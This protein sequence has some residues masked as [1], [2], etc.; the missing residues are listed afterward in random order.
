[1]TPLDLNDADL[2]ADPAAV[3]A[4][5]RPNTVEVRFAAEAGRIETLEG[6]VDHDSGAAI[7]QGVQGERWPLGA[8]RFRTLYEPMP[9]TLPGGNGTYRKKPVRVLAK[10]V[11]SA[12]FSV[13]VGPRQQPIVGRPGDWLI[14]YSGTK[15][16]IVSDEVF[17]L[18]YDVI[19]PEP[20]RAE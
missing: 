8:N 16:S 2:S 19:G 3:V 9:G 5:S 10:R 20:G 13:K 7:V 15:R 14:Q 1:M 17:R 6:P 12:P 18:S 4:V 11:L